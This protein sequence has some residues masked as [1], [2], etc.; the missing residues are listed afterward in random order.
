MTVRRNTDGSFGPAQWVNLN[1]PTGG[2]TT[3]FTSNDSVADNANVGLVITNQ[4][5]FSYQARW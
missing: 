3:L 2:A 4:G 1:V 5:I